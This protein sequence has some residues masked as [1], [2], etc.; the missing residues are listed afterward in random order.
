MMTAASRTI[1]TRP[2]ST[3]SSGAA[4]I[5][6]TYEGDA[7]VEML[8]GIWDGDK[9]DDL[10]RRRNDD[11]PSGSGELQEDDTECRDH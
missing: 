5:G 8:T 6:Y 3:N 9:A 11:I 4:R 7:A 2:R 10:H 1:P